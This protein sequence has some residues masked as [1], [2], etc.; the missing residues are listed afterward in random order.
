MK[1]LR[2]KLVFGYAAVLLLL[3]VVATVGYLSITSFGDE[4]RTLVQ[5][6]L[7]LLE[8]Y[9]E[10]SNAITERLALARGYLL[11]PENS[12]FY[13]DFRNRTTEIGQL[14]QE[15]LRNEQAKS[16][17]HLLYMSQ[18]WAIS[19]E[20]NVFAAVRVGDFETAMANAGSLVGMGNEIVD[21]LQIALSEQRL[22][23][24][25]REAELASLRSRSTKVIGAVSLGACAAGLIL[26]LFLS[27]SIS[28]PIVNVS[29]RLELVAD[30]DLTGEELSTSTK[31]LHCTVVGTAK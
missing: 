31:D 18:E 16:I 24:N 4:V 9:N 28:T 21:G 27:N 20:N 13:D 30:G 2:M 1:S 12:V 26:A 19:A 25:E 23:M 15:L 29:K 7:V 8:N 10:L 3:G 22:Y 6:D 11:Y 17:H 14:E 5:E